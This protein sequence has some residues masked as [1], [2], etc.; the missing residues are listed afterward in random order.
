MSETMQE[1]HGSSV[2]PNESLEQVDYVASLQELYVASDEAIEVCRPKLWTAAERVSATL[3]NPDQQRAVALYAGVL[4][5]HYFGKPN[6]PIPEGMVLTVESDGDPGI[7]LDYRIPYIN[8]QL[9]SLGT[10]IAE[11]GM[12]DGLAPYFKEM[13]ERRPLV[14][15]VIKDF[16]LNSAEYQLLSSFD[17]AIVQAEPS[18]LNPY[19]RQIRETQIEQALREKYGV[20]PDETISLGSPMHLELRRD[21]YQLDRETMVTPEVPDESSSALQRARAYLTPFIATEFEDDHDELRFGRILYDPGN[22]LYV[23][24]EGEDDEDAIDEL[25]DYCT[26]ASRKMSPNIFVGDEKLR[27]IAIGFMKIAMEVILDPRSSGSYQKIL[28]TAVDQA[29]NYNLDDL[30]ETIYPSPSN[31]IYGSLQS[32]LLTRSPT[33]ETYDYDQVRSLS[34]RRYTSRENWGDVFGSKSRLATAEQ[35]WRDEN[36]QAGQVEKYAPANYRTEMRLIQTRERIEPMGARSTEEDLVITLSMRAEPGIVPY[37]PGYELVSISPFYDR[38]GFRVDPE[39]DPYQT[40]QVVINKERREKLYRNYESI[41][42]AEL[43]QQ[44]EARSR[45]TVSELASLIRSASIYHV[46]EKMSGLGSDDPLSSS[47]TY[48]DVFGSF[49]KVVLSGKLHVQCTGAAS[50]L[51]ESLGIAFGLG[52]SAITSGN[53][54]I[55]PTN[56]FISMAGHAQ[57]VFTHNGKQYILDSTPSHTSGERPGGAIEETDYYVQNRKA[58]LAPKLVLADHDREVLTREPLPEKTLD[59]QITNL[60]DSMVERSKIV[61]GLPNNQKLYELL[62]KLPA[63]DPARSTFELLLQ[64]Q[65]GKLSFEEIKTKAEYVSACSEATPDTR[66]R[67]GFGQY[68]VSYLEQLRHAAWGLQWAYERVAETK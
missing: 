21:L 12:N 53:N 4:D 22:G 48:L 40:C 59:E 56:D 14:Q 41:G 11:A 66:M 18:P 68:T 27:E 6:D 63:S 31:Y 15:K 23:A 26:Q 61:F 5:W 17:D 32:P 60:V 54:V 64:A 7:S 9:G 65:R 33:G 10:R 8:D 57:T 25:W 24:G 34:H 13:K 19:W 28:E 52:S 1:T 39:G 51:K 30:N 47:M 46:P 49:S 42:L 58:P 2:E 45:L 29:I 62:I 35:L 67:M 37:I 44:V 3:L 50:F 36:F 55:N 16:I 43:A 38:Y 20:E